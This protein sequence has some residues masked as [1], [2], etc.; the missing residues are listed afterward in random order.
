MEISDKKLADLLIQKGLITEKV[1]KSFLEQAEV[2]GMSLENIL[3]ERE[4]IPDEKLGAVMAELYEV[5]FVKVS[6]RI[7]PED[8]LRT[9]SYTLASTQFLMAFEK[10]ANELSIAMNNVKNYE[11]ANFLER[12]TGLVIKRF[13]AT[14][15]D[16]K[17]ALKFYNRDV[18]EKFNKLLKSGL[19]DPT[20][21]ESLKDTAKILDT[22][23]LFAY[24]NDA[25]DIHIEPHKNFLGIRYRIDGLLKTIAELPVSILD[26]ITTRIKVLANLPT[27]EHRAAL[28]GRF[29]IELENNEITLRVSIVPTYEGEKT[30]MRVLS[31]SNQELNIET[32]GY[33]EKNMQII[34][35]NIVKTNGMILI[36]GPTGSGKTTTLYSILKLLNS[37]EI[38]ISTIEDPVEYRLE[39]VNQIQ[40]NPKT[41]LTFSTGLRSLLRQDPDVVMVGEIRDQETAGIGINAALTGHLVLATLHTNDAASTLPRLIDMGIEPFLISA[42]VKVVIAQRLVRIICPKCKISYELTLEQIQSICTKFNINQN[43]KALFEEAAKKVSNEKNTVTFYRGAG[44]ATCGQTGFKGRFSIAEVIDVSDTIKKLLL[45]ENSPQLLEEAARKEGMVPML[46]DGMNKVLAGVTTIEEVLRVMRS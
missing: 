3:F 30:V 12:K 35:N 1:L 25:S 10:K 17:Q 46:V 4:I 43:L 7:I 38:N 23:I 28:D 19:E 41:N 14:K 9:V 36:T 32:L 29:K 13:Y 37:P 31:S 33:S 39:G 44:C 45:T 15:R 40:V 2:K 27:D 8:L 34:H 42:T 5:P 22:I 6:E 26:L 16:I 11:I 21:I 18:N 24:Q 20:K